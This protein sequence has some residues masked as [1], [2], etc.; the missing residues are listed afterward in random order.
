MHGHM[1]TVGTPA[2]GTPEQNTDPSLKLCMEAIQ[3]KNSLM[4][5]LGGDRDRVKSVLHL[6]VAI[7][8]NEIQDKRKGG[9]KK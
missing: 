5:K 6:A 2:P 4:T 9:H 3:C 8:T 1:Q 7:V